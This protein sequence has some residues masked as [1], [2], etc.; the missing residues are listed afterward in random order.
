M[1]I[2]RSYSSWL[3]K[4]TDLFKRG[5]HMASTCAKSSN[6]VLFPAKIGIAYATF[7][8]FFFHSDIRFQSQQTLLTVI[9]IA[10]VGV[11]QRVSDKHFG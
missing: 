5:S 9:L 11:L 8:V 6:N 1:K 3:E 4:K 7:A 10:G 2:N